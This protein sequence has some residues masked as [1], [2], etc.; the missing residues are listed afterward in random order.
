MRYKR[1]RP[2]GFHLSRGHMGEGMQS[3][4]KRG[5]EWG[6]DRMGHVGKDMDDIGLRFP[7]RGKLD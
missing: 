4:H 1:E 3:A 5:E 7:K 2:R 6:S